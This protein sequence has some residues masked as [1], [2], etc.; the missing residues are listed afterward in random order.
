MSR[1]AV[2][3]CS[4][5]KLD[6]VQE[7]IPKRDAVQ[8]PKGGPLLKDSDAGAVVATQ[9]ISRGEWA[10]PK[11]QFRQVTPAGQSQSCRDGQCEPWQQIVPS[12]IVAGTAWTPSSSSL[13]LIP[14]D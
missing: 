12:K 1:R 5:E 10:E 11:L 14:I 3:D 9:S 6:P 8:I 4:A 7:F 2:A 13:P